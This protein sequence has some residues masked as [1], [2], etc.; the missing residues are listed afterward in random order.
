MALPRRRCSSRH[1][2]NLTSPWGGQEW[3]VKNRSSVALV[4]QRLHYGEHFFVGNESP[5]VH[6]LVGIDGLRQLAGIRGKVLVAVGEL[7]PLALRSPCL[8]AVIPAINKWFYRAGKRGR[9]A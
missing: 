6:E 2:T 4:T 5:A 8:G 1:S 9:H 3:G 7:P